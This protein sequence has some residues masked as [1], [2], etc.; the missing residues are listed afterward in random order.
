MSSILLAEKNYI[1][2]VMFSEFFNLEYEVIIDDN[3]EYISIT[4]DNEARLV[5]CCEL[6]NIE[7][8]LSSHHLPKVRYVKNKFTPECDIPNLYGTGNVEVSDSEI[9]CNIDI[10]SSCFFMLSRMEE[11]NSTIKDNHNRFQSNNSIAFKFGFLDRPIVDEYTEM[12]WNMLSYLQP[13]LIR[14]QHNFKKFITCD[15]DWP[16]DPV[17]RSLKKSLKK[18]VGDLLKRKD[19]MSAVTTLKLYL[20]HQLGLKQGDIYRSSIDWMMDVN[21]K[22][23]NK[24]SFYFISFA[25]TELDSTFDL[26]SSDMIELLQSISARGHEIGLHPGYNTFQHEKNFKKSVETLKHAMDIA[27]INQQSI[28]GRMHYLRWDASITASLWA[29]NGLAY[30][31]TLS[32]ADLS[33]FRCG[34]CREFSM[35]DLN[36]KSHLQLKQRPLINMECTVISPMYEGLGYSNQAMERFKYFIRKTSQYNGNYTLLWHNSHFSNAKDKQFYK[37]LIK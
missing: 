16:Y 20:Y 12:L 7:D 30:D 15:V 9:I 5:V 4:L 22:V 11:K 27:G 2:D 31:S 33:G 13:S 8:Y 36:E 19:I 25:T 26:T 14:K 35:F 29:K 3:H 28:G 37:E 21:E 34:T 23:G 1:I 6:L 17:R 10:F 32:F 18:F 24:I